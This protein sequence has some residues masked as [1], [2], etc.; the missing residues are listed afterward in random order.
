MSE[1]STDLA[2][3]KRLFVGA[4][5]PELLGRGQKEIRGSGYIEGPTMT[6]NPSAFSQIWGSLMVGPLSNEDVK[7]SKDIPGAICGQNYSPYSLAVVGNAAI[8]DNMSINGNLDVGGEIKSQGDVT[9]FCGGHRLSSKK[10]FDIPHPSRSGWRLRHTCPEAPTNDVYIRGRV[11]IPYISLPEYWKD[12]VDLRSIT[13][14]LTP[15]GSHQDVIVKRIDENKVY[16]QSKG[17]APIDCFYHVYAERKDG[18]KL[19]SEYPGKS[20]DDYP[21]DNTQYNINY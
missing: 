17:N 3:G 11:T 1:V 20:P 9:S 12:F 15:V 13:V 14:S 7:G 4:G 18:D 8:F 21:G 16:L 5:K 19:I 10:N 2:T 6:G